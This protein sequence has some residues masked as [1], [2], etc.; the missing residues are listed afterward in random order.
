MSFTISDISVNFM[1][2]FKDRHNFPRFGEG[3]SH[4]LVTNELRKGNGH[5]DRF[6][7]I[8]ERTNSFAEIETKLGIAKTALDLCTLEFLLRQF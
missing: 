7:P 8:C 4:H 5:K 6:S 3:K 2:S 1:S